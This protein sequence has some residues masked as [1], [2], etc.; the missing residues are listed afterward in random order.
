[1]VRPSR[2]VLV[3][4]GQSAGS[5]LEN[6]EAGGIGGWRRQ[7]VAGRWVWRAD[8]LWQGADGHPYWAIEEP[9]EG[10]RDRGEAA[11]HKRWLDQEHPD[12]AGDWELWYSASGAWRCLS[13]HTSLDEAQ[14]A[15]A[16]VAADRYRMAELNSGRHFREP[17]GEGRRPL[18]VGDGRDDER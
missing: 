18:T 8:D 16:L 10:R 9:P 14:A 12:R 11:T 2:V 3:I 6:S 15:A 5:Q 13:F 1:M 4:D 7:R 17:A